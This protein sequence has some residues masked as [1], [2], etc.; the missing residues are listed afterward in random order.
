MILRRGFSPSIARDLAENPA[1]VRFALEMR[2]KD[3]IQAWDSDGDDKATV[4]EVVRAL[5]RWQV[6]VH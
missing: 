2:A 5:Y 6:S 4:K 1:N 3:A